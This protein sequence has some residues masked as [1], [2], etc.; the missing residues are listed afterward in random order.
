M[1]LFAHFSCESGILVAGVDYAATWVQEFAQIY[2]NKN[3][4]LIF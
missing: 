1:L 3:L 4:D 2:N